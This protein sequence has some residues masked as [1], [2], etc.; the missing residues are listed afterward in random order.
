MG[1]ILVLKMNIRQRHMLSSKDIRELKQTLD[2]LFD[3]NTISRIFTEKPKIEFLRIEN[4]D[5]IIVINNIL[6]FWIT[7][8]RYVPCLTLLNDPNI[9]F[10]IK[11]VTV[12]KGAIKFVADGAD[13][14]RPGITKIDSS[15]R[16]GDIIK[17][18]E[19]LHGRA[20]AVGVAMFDAQ[21][22]QKMDKGKVI[23]TIHSVNDAIWEFSKTF[24]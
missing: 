16:K 19:E 12:D 6:S 9:K 17:I 2:I 5:E 14:M 18:Q 3:E 15:I 24:R 23:Q 11:S 7:K 21:V 22:M 8:E 4:R 20:L 1:S 13:I 10:P